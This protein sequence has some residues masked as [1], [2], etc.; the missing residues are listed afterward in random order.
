MFKQEKWRSG[1]AFT[2]NEALKAQHLRLTNLIDAMTLAAEAVD[3]AGHAALLS[4]FSHEL[5]T[6][7]GD[8]IEWLN[9]LGVDTTDHLEQH[10]HVLSTVR[11][12]DTVMQE[13]GQ[14]TL[15]LVDLLTEAL[16]AEITY[17]QRAVAQ[18]SSE[19]LV[20]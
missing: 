13:T 10:T 8:E 15:A 16:A 14:L 20:A 7:L 11:E 2:G 3:G 17:D 4:G 6:H 19:K 1:D 12:M 5:T 9:T 18:I